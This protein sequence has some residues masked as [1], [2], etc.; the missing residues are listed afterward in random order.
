LYPDEIGVAAG[1]E[2]GMTMGVRQPAPGVNPD[3]SQPYG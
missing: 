1:E 2:S 3:E